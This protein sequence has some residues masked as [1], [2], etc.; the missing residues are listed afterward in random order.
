MGL[1]TV[2]RYCAAC[3]SV[4]SGI[5]G[6]ISPQAV[7]DRQL[8]QTRLCLHRSSV[9]GGV[10]WIVAVVS[11]RVYDNTGGR[12][13]LH[14]A[15]SY[16]TPYSLKWTLHIWLNITLH[17]LHALCS[18]ITSSLFHS[19][20]KTYLFYKSYPSPVV[21]LFPP[22]VPLWTIARTIS[23]DI[24]YSF[25]VFSFPYFFRFCAEC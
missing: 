18:S 7:V 25:F 2:Q 11:E 9:L 23:S 17:W 1:T 19:R 20:L 24:S 3:D 15:T 6:R 5:T 8:S 4:W 16:F 12:R 13:C 21:S 22:G 10:H 14:V